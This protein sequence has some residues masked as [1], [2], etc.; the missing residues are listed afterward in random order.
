MLVG[1][2]AQGNGRRAL[3]A[4][5]CICSGASGFIMHIKVTY[6][7]G[8]DVCG[9]RA[10]RAVVPSHTSVSPLTVPAQDRPMDLDMGCTNNISARE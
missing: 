8:L 5:A 4:D 9:S 7:G 1:T 6:A 3:R 10:L 2:Y